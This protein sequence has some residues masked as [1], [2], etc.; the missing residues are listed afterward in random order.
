MNT[1]Q[2]RGGDGIEDYRMH[3]SQRYLDLT[4]SKLELAR[5]P[6]E[7]S[8]DDDDDD[9][10]GD[11][12]N[13]DSQGITKAE[14]EPL[15][16]YWLDGFDFRAQEMHLNQQLPQYRTNIPWL[17][18]PHDRSIRLHFVHRKSTQKD[19]IPLLFCHDWGTSFLEITRVIEALCEPVT[20]PTQST[21][22][23]QAF[24]VVCPSIPGFG[25]GDAIP[26]H[27]AGLLDT[28]GLFQHLMTRLDYNQYM[29]CGAGWGFRIARA[30]SQAYPLN[31]RAL[32][33]SNPLVPQ[34]SFTSTPI[35]WLKYQLARLTGARSPWLSFG[36]VP[37]DFDMASNYQVKVGAMNV[38]ADG[39]IHLAFALADSPTGLLAFMLHLLNPM[40]GR[41]RQPS[42][43]PPRNDSV[44]LG[45]ILIHPWSPTDVLTWTMLYWLSGPEAPLRWLRN[46]CKETQPESA[47][48]T[49]RST[50]PL[51]VSQFRWPGASARGMVLSPPVWTSAYCDLVWL[52]R[53][54][55]G[56]EVK[57][58]AWEAADSLVLDLR[59][60]VA[61][62][63]GRNVF[64]G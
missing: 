11:N 59:D 7:L 51:G 28:A 41:P 38:P 16:D 40:H 46:A 58:P 24:H 33:T 27:H 56:R 4:K 31:C 2:S 55:A 43:H 34:P 57:W 54:N 25:F 52:R 14:L 44:H 1:T 6:R 9:D 47:Y 62:L 8:D 17:S 12:V 3:V 15:L 64:S 30:I 10:N 19:A 5:L 61:D 50:V 39:N 35:A 26:D 13:H 36:Y 29:A 53:H 48:W 49:K 60:F 45:S 21:T 32:F 42:S 18:T 22:H 63:R 37:S 20:T 23:H